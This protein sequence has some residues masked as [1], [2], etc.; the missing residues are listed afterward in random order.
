MRATSVMESGVI[1]T[2]QVPDSARAER[3]SHLDL[4]HVRGFGVA[5][6]GTHID[7]RLQDD[8]A[9]DAERENP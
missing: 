8:D 4:A 9:E 2:S 6:D 3:C 7:R 5:L 1:D